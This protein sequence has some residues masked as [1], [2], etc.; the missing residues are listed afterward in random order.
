MGLQ[1]SFERF[2]GRAAKA[3]I[4]RERM[5][6]VA[7]TGAIG[8]ST[9][10]QAIAAVLRSDLS[11]NR[12]RVTARNYNN[13]L[14]VPLTVFG[15]PAPGR[16]P[17]KWIKLLGVGALAR[18][19]FWRSGMRTLVLEMG[20][21]KPGD[22]AYLTSIAQPDV[23]VVT[24]ITPDDPSGTP[25]H[26]ANY[27]SIDQLVE[28]KSQL[29]RAL[30]SGG[31]AI[32]NADDKRVF[33]MRHLTHEHVLTFGEADGSD[34]RI[35]KTSVRMEESQHGRIPVG[36]EISLESYQRTYE[37]FIP[38]VYG[39]SVAYAVAAA[40]AV[41]QAMDISEEQVA[42]LSIA[43]N[44]M[45]GRT[46]IIPGIKRTTLLDDSYNASPSSTLSSLRDLAGLPLEPGQRRAACIGEMRELGEKAEAAH[47]M[48]GAEAAR[49]GLDLLV[50]CGIFA[51]AMAEG[52]LANGMNPEAVK[53]IED[54]PEAG[55]FIQDWIKPG[56]IVLAKASEGTIKT[57]GVRM[58]R[59]I[60]ELMADPMH[61]EQLLVRQGAVWQRK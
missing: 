19:G 48:I 9:T 56:D 47:R 5:F 57:K 61:A 21:D 54:T 11:E 32:L 58:E 7:V 39:T 15:K 17:L 46:R 38:G 24:A 2:L 16:N 53:V 51:H 40:V 59:V 55:L 20:A 44:P 25:V 14:G 26:A 60:K 6:V 22:L 35:A 49:L 43:F 50:V 45:P 31:T 18:I 1:T 41:G 52:A 30:R 3:V 42:A 4:R 12:V 27:S 34:V 36:L 23:A 29:V 8:K 37:L 28:E 10:K 13:E 33:A